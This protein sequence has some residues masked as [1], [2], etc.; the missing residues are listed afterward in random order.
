[1][2][3]FVVIQNFCFCIVYSLTSDSSVLDLTALHND[4]L[5]VWMIYSM[6]CFSF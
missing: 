6:E 5:S 2:D 3:I 4:L 1:M